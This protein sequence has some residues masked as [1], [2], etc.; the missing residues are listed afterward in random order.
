MAHKHK[1]PDRLGLERLFERLAHETL[2]QMI[3]HRVADDPTTMGHLEKPDMKPAK[4][5]KQ[6][7]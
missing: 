3:G 7:A 4:W 1:I 5:A 2:T 6:G